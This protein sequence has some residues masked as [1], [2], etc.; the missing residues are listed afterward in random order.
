VIGRLELPYRPQLLKRVEGKLAD[1]NADTTTIAGYYAESARPE[2]EDPTQREKVQKTLRAVYSK[3][4]VDELRVTPERVLRGAQV[5]I[6]EQQIT[7]AEI[8][9]VEAGD[10]KRYDIRMRLSDEGRRRLWKYSMDK[11]G[12][13]VML[14]VDGVAV[15]APKIQHQLTQDELTISGSEDAVLAR[16]AVDGMNKVVKKS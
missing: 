14:I 10:K 7:D 4:R 5:L 15:A 11:V 6:N 3:A 2:I 1:K 13:Y 12:T 8:H 16:E 9:E